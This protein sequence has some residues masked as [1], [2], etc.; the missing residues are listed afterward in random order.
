MPDTIENQKV[1][2]QQRSQKVGCG[3]PQASICACFCLQTGA[4]LSHKIG[5]K[6]SH[7][8]PLLREQW[9]T[10]KPDDIFL[11]DKGFCSYFDVHNFKTQ[12]VDSVITLAR[13]TPF[14]AGESV[15][16][17]G[18]ND[19]L[20]NWRKPVKSKRSSYSLEGWEKLPVKLLLR[21]IKVTINQ[22]GFRASSF[23]I[24]TT[25]LD[26]DRYP[27][28]DIADLYF[29][30]WDVELF[31]RDI[32]TTMGMDILRCQSPDMV[33]KEI[34]MHLIAY[35]CI[36][37]LMME[38]IKG[39]GVAVRRVSFKGCV[40]ALRQWEP[41]LN[42]TKMSAQERYRLLGLLYDS[43]AEYMVPERPG[44]SEPRAVKRRPKPFQLLTAPR[45]EMKETKHRGKKY[46]KAA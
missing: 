13:R 20:I 12:G 7:E 21:Q 28:A 10:F 27:A 34:L 44:R 25:L 37:R 19:L 32:K 24:I 22:P 30:R 15:K 39:A 35:N 17:L 2:P 11:G 9:D 33:R 29:Q 6:K 23:Y 14:T 3:F 4:L 26:A 18:D 43:I 45:N 42:Q 38:S 36:R 41:H 16:V 40:Q 8:L 31:F 5:N 1:W 46:G